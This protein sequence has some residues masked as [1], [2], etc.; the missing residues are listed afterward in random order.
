LPQDPGNTVYVEMRVPADGLEVDGLAVMVPALGSTAGTYTFDLLKN[1]VSVLV[2]PV[3][4]ETLTAG[5][6]STATVLSDGT[7]H[8]AAGDELRA[9]AV[10]DNADLTGFLGGV[11][12]TVQIGAQ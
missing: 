10:S 6:W 4:L 9:Q 2:A 1:G 12:F 8:L 5:T 3:D 7:E 11:C